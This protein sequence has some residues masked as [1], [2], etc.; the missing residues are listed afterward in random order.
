[1]NGESHAIEMMAA[2]ERD[3]FVCVEDV[4]RLQLVLNI[5]GGLAAAV[6]LSLL[7][8]T[9]ANLTGLGVVRARPFQVT[10][11]LAVL[12]WAPLTMLLTRLSRRRTRLSPEQEFRAFL[13]QYPGTLGR[14]GWSTINYGLR[15]LEDE[16]KQITGD[17]A[18]RR[19]LVAAFG[20]RRLRVG[21]PLAALGLGLAGACTFT[22]AVAG[23]SMAATLNLLLLPGLGLAAL[24]GFRFFLSPL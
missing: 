10:L 16:L 9:A 11:A 17:T 19:R 5:A 3:A 15:S 18:L 8:V 4:G 7:L 14:V 23:G 1:M 12:S 20:L 6:G 21:L 22:V 24:G 13:D 2:L